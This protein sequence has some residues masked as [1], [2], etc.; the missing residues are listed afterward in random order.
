[1]DEI[2]SQASQTL[3]LD[4]A[5]PGLLVRIGKPLHPGQPSPRRPVDFTIRNEVQSLK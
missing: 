1:M 3:G 5:K 4:F 2:S